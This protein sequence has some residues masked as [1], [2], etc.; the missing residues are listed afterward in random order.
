MLTVIPARDV[1]TV[2]GTGAPEDPPF[3]AAV[4]ALFAVRAALGGRDDA[5]LEGSYAQDGDPLRFDLE[6]PAGWHWRLLVPAPGRVDGGRGRHRG[7]SG[8]ERAVH[9]RRARATLVAQLLHRGPYADEVPSIAALD[10]FVHEQG[11]EPVGPHTE[12]YLD[13]PRT[14]APARAADAAADAGALNVRGS[15]ASGGAPSAARCASWRRPA[16][17][18]WA[19]RRLREPS[20]LSRASI[21]SISLAEMLRGSFVRCRCSL[22]SG[23]WPSSLP[24]TTS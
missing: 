7:A 23:T 17:G 21:D 19:A 20:A 8:S 1:L 12:V 16:A 13:D 14:T 24:T 11:R 10:A 2:D 5:P 18:P 4:R 3:T 9:L 15:P 6:P 22:L